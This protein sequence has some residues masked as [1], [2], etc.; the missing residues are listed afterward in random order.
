ML[1]VVMSIGKFR[2]FFP[3]YGLAFSALIK[4]ILLLDLRGERAEV[5]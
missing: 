1:R 3:S 5:P 4:Y 2:H